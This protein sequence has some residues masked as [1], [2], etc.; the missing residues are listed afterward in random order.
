[1]PAQEESRLSLRP[2]SEGK[3]Q[4][5]V[6]ILERPPVFDG[7][8]DVGSAG[9]RALTDRELTI[10]VASPTG[11]GELWTAGWRWWKDRPR[12]SLA[13]AV[14]A[15]GGRPGIWRLDGFWERQAYV[16]R[17]RS[18][19]G[20]TPSAGVSREERRR[21][22][23]SFSDWLRPDIRLETGAALDK[24]IGRGSYLSLEGSV[25]RRWARDR[26]ALG[27]QAAGWASLENG[28]PF[29]TG[30]LSV[31]WSSSGLERCDAWLG[32]LGISGA[33]SKAPLALWSGAGTGQGRSPLLRAHPLL[34]GGIL[35]GSV[36]GR[37]LVHGTVERQIWA[38]ELGFVRIGGAIFMD[39]AKAWGSTPAG[40]I[41][42]QID[43]GAGIRLG[44]LGIRGQLRLDAARGLRDGRSAL[45][46]GWQVP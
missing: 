10:D 25:E 12:V 33:T 21:T 7:P 38:W 18:G 29:E 13:L 9:V 27:A 39:G 8:W 19:S 6:T 14:P 34:D 11:N 3:A 15:A 32:R 40:R 46:V 4:V 42:W 26:L 23:L 35:S 37:S 36:F 17:A 1:M 45:S 22:A 43:G 28:P 41:P 31:R 2:E 16:A 44:G 24:W 5:N 20:A 30:G